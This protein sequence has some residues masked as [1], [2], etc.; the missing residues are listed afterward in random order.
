MRGRTAVGIRAS[1][2]K[3][4]KIGL[5]AVVLL[6]GLLL[7]GVVMYVAYHRDLGA[8]RERS[9]LNARVFADELQ[10]DLMSGES[11]TRAL[12]LTVA[13]S[14]EHRIEGFQ[15]VAAH[16]AAD[17]DAPISS[18]RLAPSGIVTAIYPEMPEDYG[19]NIFDSPK[20]VPSA[21][22]SQQNR[23]M[24]LQGPVHLR[25]GD[26]M[27]LIMR[28]PV[29]LPDEVK[30]PESGRFWGFTIVV[31]KM[32][33]VFA[34]TE[35]NIKK[36]QCAY[37]LEKT[38]VDD[39]DYKVLIE[40][41]TPVE[42]PE[43]YTFFYGGCS[44][45]MSVSP[46]HGWQP[47]PLTRA[48]GLLGLVCLLLFTGIVYFTLYLRERQEGL[49][50][51]A[52][53]D[54]L[55]GLLNRHG[56][57]QAAKEILTREDPR[58][59]VFVQLDI[60]DFKYINDLFSH[61]VGDEALRHLSTIM[62]VFFPRTAVLGRSGGD[63]FIIVLYGESLAQLERM[64]KD[65]SSLRKEFNYRQHVY[66]YTISMGYAVMMP[67]M[68]KA[69]DGKDIPAVLHAA[70]VALYNVKLLGKNGCCRYEKGM[71]KMK[72]VQLGFSLRD[73]AIHLP[74]AI[75][76]YD[77]ESEDI[78]FANSELISM[79][80]C[81]DLEDFLQYTNHNFRGIVHPEDYEDVETSIWRQIYLN[82]LKGFADDAVNYRIITKQGKVV[83]VIDRGRLVDSDYY[84]KIFYV[85]LI[86]DDEMNDDDVQ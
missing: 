72:K 77:A 26:G 1:L 67:G 35:E 41:D 71:A 55:T 53:T 64:V 21:S 11:I 14:P 51:L 5:T 80:G 13:N 66:R 86:T 47:A 60:D 39:E 20:L 25:E 85:V 81:E 82:R 7:W 58:Y 6:C 4:N 31:L 54:N 52:V 84:G 37:R 15:I 9:Q 70:D 2:Q 23:K 69:S 27:G 59:V 30:G 68:P 56:L 8:A 79:F 10:Q 83:W 33:D 19:M 40:S 76:I 49:R 12:A 61:Q 62:R 42:N 75:L 29:Y 3:N 34:H 32:P 45:C 38:E 28:M 22:Y 50:E 44:W 63:E 46:Q 43:V 78:L 74:A 48:L 57:E 16:M 24:V 65:F 17:S 73:V 18:I 36:T